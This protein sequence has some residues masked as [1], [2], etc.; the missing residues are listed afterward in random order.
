MAAGGGAGCGQHAGLQRHHNINHVASSVAA[1]N[2]AGEEVGPH[3]YH[4]YTDTQEEEMPDSPSYSQPGYHDSFQYGETSASASNSGEEEDER[5]YEGKRSGDP[6]TG[7]AA[8]KRRKQSK[9]IRLGS[10]E[11]GEGE[12]EGEAE[13]EGEGEAVEEGEI[14]RYRRE[15]GESVED[16]ASPGQGDSP[17]NLSAVSKQSEEKCEPPPGE[18]S[19]SSA[20]P[21]LLTWCFRSESTGQGA[22]AEPGERRLQISAGREHLSVQPCRL[23]NGE[24]HVSVLR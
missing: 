5:D 19:Q 20:A 6:L 23:R 14:T 16:T 24:L 4:S 12:A 3:H 18:S 2:T 8:K 9:P 7:L 22:H 17:L 10:E 15:S 13:G 21:A 1:V 11:G